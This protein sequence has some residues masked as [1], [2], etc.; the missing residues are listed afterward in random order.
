MGAIRDGM[1]DKQAQGFVLTPEQMAKDLEMKAKDAQ[2]RM[3]KAKDDM[4]K[5]E[6]EM[7]KLQAAHKALVEPA[8]AK[9]HFT[10]EKSS[11][12][13]ASAL[14]PFVCSGVAACSASFVIHPI[15]LAKVRLQL[16][17]AQ[18]L[19]KTNFVAMIGSM[20][21]NEGIS[22]CYAGLSASIA[23]QAIYGTA[24]LALHSIF[25]D[26]MQEM[27][28]GGS[29]PFWKKAV[30]GMGSG[31]IAVCI[32]TPFDVALVRM[33][34]DGMKPAAERRGYK[35][36][37]DALIRVSSE[38]GPRTLWSGLA[39]NIYRGISMNVGMMAFYDQ[40]KET[41]GHMVNDPDPSRPL[42]ITKMGSAAV[43]GFMCAFLSLPFDMIK[44]RL[45]D[46]KPL[47]DGSMP[48]KGVGDCMR[49]LIAAEGV[50]SLWTGFSAY[51]FRCAPH[52]MTIL[53]VREE[54]YKMY[55]SMTGREVAGLLE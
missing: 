2:A 26:K 53:L 39:P 28:G 38:E 7:H 22:A 45:Q 29:L 25:S 19:P 24:R 11:T 14:R 21:K 17:S 37:V 51:Y 55:D 52:A 41:V 5:A 15:D 6:A 27:Q 4:L 42:M 13:V 40:A 46:M 43:A 54:I 50:T 12:G 31:A 35:N 48:Y 20:A 23:R 36:V 44:S 49:K 8:A 30:S 34:A 9:Q 1:D 18:G 3:V 33:Q 47:K 10:V 32:G 16:A